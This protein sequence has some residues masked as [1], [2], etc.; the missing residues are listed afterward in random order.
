[1]HVEA[2]VRAR[3]SAHPTKEEAGA[4]LQVP[5]ALTMAAQAPHQEEAGAGHGPVGAHNGYANAH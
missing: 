5:L 3:S 4:G 1:M 2:V